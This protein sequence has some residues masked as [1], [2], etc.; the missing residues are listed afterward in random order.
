VIFGIDH[1]QLAMP[2]GQESRARAFFGG[3]FGMAEIAKPASLIGRGGCWFACGGQ[4]LHVGAEAAFRP[5][6]KAHPA[7]VVQDLRK[8]QARLLAEGISIKHAPDLPNAWRIFVDDPFG[9]R[10]ELIERFSPE[11]QTSQTLQD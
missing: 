4:E 8:M 7:F 10:I 3:I 6:K 5:A 9:N 11:N 1:I 2:T